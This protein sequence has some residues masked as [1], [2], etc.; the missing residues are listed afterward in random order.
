MAVQISVI[1]SQPT[2]INFI[3]VH[4]QR[5]ICFDWHKREDHLSIY[6][7]Y[8]CEAE[9]IRTGK[10]EQGLMIKSINLFTV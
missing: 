6:I 1:Y 9:G 4:W 3:R 5:C 7:I 10:G 8:F 2:F